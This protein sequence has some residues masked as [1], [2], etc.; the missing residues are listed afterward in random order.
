MSLDYEKGHVASPAELNYVCERARL[1]GTYYQGM[2]WADSQNRWTNKYNMDL[3][4]K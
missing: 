2:C 3:Q 4:I 1:G